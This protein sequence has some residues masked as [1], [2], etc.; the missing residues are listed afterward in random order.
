MRTHSRTDTQMRVNSNWLLLVIEDVVSMVTV[1]GIMGLVSI[2]VSLSEWDVGPEL[3]L[4]RLPF[5]CSTS[6]PC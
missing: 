6:Q 5:I 3:G 1:R 2:C 4:A